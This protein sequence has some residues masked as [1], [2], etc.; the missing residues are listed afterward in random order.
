LPVTSNATTQAHE[1]VSNPQQVD[2]TKSDLA[3]FN[4]GKNS[5]RPICFW[6]GAGR[7]WRAI[8]RYLSAPGASRT[9]LLLYVLYY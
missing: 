2:K 8:L 5:A 1:N 4:S 3:W 6:W 7:I 9:S